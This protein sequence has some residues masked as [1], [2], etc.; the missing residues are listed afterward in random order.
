[1]GFNSNHFLS[2]HAWLGPSLQLYKYLRESGG[3]EDMAVNGSSTP[4]VFEYEVP[5]Q[6]AL[7]LEK[8]TLSI[9]NAGITPSN[10]GGVSALSNGLLIQA[11]DAENVV[12]LDYTDSVPIKNLADFLSIGGS[13]AKLFDDSLGVDA[14]GITIPFGSLDALKAGEKIRIVVQDNLTGMDQMKAM[15]HGVLLDR[16]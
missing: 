16:S 4:V 5:A 6:R 15:V 7:L 9:E 11:V 10:F 2:N 14:M 8:I 3:S 1:M 12:L 13:G